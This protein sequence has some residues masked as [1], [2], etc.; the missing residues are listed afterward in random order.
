LQ[1]LGH[2]RQFGGAYRRKNDLECVHWWLRV[3]G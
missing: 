3:E 2:A 1:V